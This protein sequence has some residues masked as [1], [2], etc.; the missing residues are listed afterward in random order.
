M[1]Q[2]G[3]CWAFQ[4]VYTDRYYGLPAETQIFVDKLFEALNSKSYL[5][6]PV[7]EQ[8]ASTSRPADSHQRTDKDEP[9]KEEVRRPWKCTGHQE[10]CN[11]V[12]CMAV[13]QKQQNPTAV[14]ISGLKIALNENCYL[15]CKCL[16]ESPLQWGGGSC[17][18]VDETFCG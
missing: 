18:N 11:V 3:Y 2:I 15:V 13:D 16:C 6:Q 1:P 7:P 12:K 4:S 17:S 8:P 14:N 5:P 10:I 9:R